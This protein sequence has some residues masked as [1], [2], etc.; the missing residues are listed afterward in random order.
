MCW[1]AETARVL[2][3]ELLRSSFVSS[4]AFL[5]AAHLCGLYI[6]AARF[7]PSC[8]RRKVAEARCELV[9]E[10]ASLYAGDFAASRASLLGVSEDG[11]VALA[12]V[13]SLSLALLLSSSLPVF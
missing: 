12:E 10:V 2:V 3:D 11:E 8:R 4:F 13:A 6:G 5:K 9:S 1:A 7:A